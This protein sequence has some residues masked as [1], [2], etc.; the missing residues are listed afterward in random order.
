TGV[1]E[2]GLF[3]GDAAGMALEQSNTSG[4]L[5][6]VS[7]ATPLLLNDLSPL[8]IA[9]PVTVA[10]LGL[11]D[12]GSIGEAGSINATTLVSLGKIGGN[13]VLDG[14]NTI[15]TLGD[16]SAAGS[17]TLDDAAA[18]AV[19]GSVTALNAS[20]TAAALNIPG[21]I[22]A[23]T[24]GLISAG[25][26]DEG[27]S[28]DANMLDAQAGGD[29]ALTGINNIGTLGGFTVTG[30]ATIADGATLSMAGP[31]SAAN[32]TVA[33]A[34]LAIPGPVSIA[35]TLLL[36]STGPVTESGSIVA[37][38]LGSEGLIG[39]TVALGGT[40]T[41]ITL[42]DFAAGG[43]VDFTDTA[44]LTIAGTF[45]APNATLAADGF[46]VPG[47]IA[48]PG[49]LSLS[50]LGAIDAPGTIMAGTLTG[51]S[52]GAVLLDGTDRIATLGD[53]HA[54]SGAFTLIDGVP[55]R[56]SGAVNAADIVL[57]APTTSITGTLATPGTLGLGGGTIIETGAIS[58]A[59]LQSQGALGGYVS[60]AGSNRIGMLGQ[61]DDAGHALS[62]VDGGPL[63]L[64]GP[65]TA[66]VVSISA[67]G[68]LTLDGIAGGGLFINGRAPA[69]AVTSQTAP[70][71]GIDSVLSVVAGGAQQLVQT[72]IFDID[73][74][75]IA[76]Q[77][78]LATQPNMLF[79]DLNTTGSASFADL[80]APN[81]TMVIS[82]GGGAASGQLD[83]KFLA[84]AGSYAGK[85]NF[86]GTLDN[87]SG[88]AAAHNSVVVPV[89]GVNYRFNACIIGS[90]NCT[91]LPV[92]T[93][94]EASPLQDF[95]LTPTRRR[96]LD[97]DVRLPGI[98]AK[99]Y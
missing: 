52:G 7:V 80:V 83:L 64:A 58:A 21:T 29:V 11:G 91:V 17:V 23:T 86:T 92:V 90:V 49:L 12:T 27:G 93:L 30:N 54:G 99:D 95:D 69:G 57:T 18:L 85:A 71:A 60:L 45:N 5:G 88:Q 67:T 82:L 62:L 75:P 20:L 14:V 50:S 96:R 77:V 73:A 98:A 26:I 34:G 15:A 66:Q 59:V 46:A 56:V 48:V 61:F 32:A 25:S 10:T 84:V 19:T 16:F 43:D 94:P 55:L 6:V 1:I 36:G 8:T 89:P 37:A 3:N 81:T 47:D 51:T 13:V 42:A 4:T 53:F 72:G 65:V 24:L 9:G 28:V 63:D 70:R 39:G 44:P 78:G 76:Q 22:A 38:T 31:F 68:M 87:V 79:V 97:R 40:N 2:T 33:A 74:G 35:G 41:I